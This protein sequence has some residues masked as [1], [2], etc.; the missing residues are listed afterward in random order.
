[1]SFEP[2]GLLTLTSDFGQRD[3]YVGAMKGAALSVAP[4]VRLV[5]IA[6]DLP[7]QDVTHA[8]RVLAASA[9]RFPR[10]TVH[11]AVVDP[12]VGTRRAPIA[13]LAGGHAFVGPDN[14]LFS[15]AV[16][17]LGGAAAC[18]SIGA[19]AHVSPTPSPTFHGRDIFSPTGAALA[20][21]LLQL[22]SLGP[23]HVPSLVR[24]ERPSTG[25]PDRVEGQVVLVDRFGNL[26]TNIRVEDLA[27]HG[28]GGEVVI[29]ALTLP[30][31]ETYATVPVGDPVA[32]VGS[33][34]WL[35]IAVRDGSAL[36]VLGLGTGSPVIARPLS[37]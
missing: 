35:E 19:H 37:T 13:I 33:E 18:H 5:D 29:G 27:A 20:A 3:G 10:G 6:H 24:A 8:A 11:V 17:H 12:G 16:E 21:G 36:D 23:A 15:L 32:V 14:G 26:V 34:G 28:A 25:T 30:L 4:E 31:S 7:A 22:D 1:M 2:N 9:P